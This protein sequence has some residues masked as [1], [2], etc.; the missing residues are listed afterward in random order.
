MT[1]VFNFTLFCCLR[2]S[3]NCIPLFYGKYYDN[4]LTREKCH[5]FPILAVQFKECLTCVLV[6]WCQRCKIAVCLQG[7]GQFVCSLFADEMSAPFN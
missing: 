1:K 4:I 2:T 6:S 7:A 3:L 5:C